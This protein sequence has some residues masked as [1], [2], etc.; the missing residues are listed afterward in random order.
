[1]GTANYHYCC[2]HLPD[3]YPTALFDPH[4]FEGFF[5]H[6]TLFYFRGVPYN[7]LP[8]QGISPEFFLNII[9]T[10]PWGVF[11][12]LFNSRL[13]WGRLVKYCF[14]FSLFIEANQ[15]IWD[16]PI[17]LGRLA[18]VDDL[19]TNTFGALVGFTIMKLLD[20]TFFHALIQKLRL[21]RP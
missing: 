15:F 19:I 4:L 7:L 11:L 16:L 13:R 3:C 10:L 9:M 6:K 14:L 18:D 21:N 8:F 17:H 12:Y 5:R 20:N 2:L 1:M